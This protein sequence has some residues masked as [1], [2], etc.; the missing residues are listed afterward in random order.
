[1]VGQH[2]RKLDLFATIPWFMWYHINKLR[3]KELCLPI[4]K[5]FNITSNYLSEFQQRPQVSIAKTRQKEIKWK[6]LAKDEIKTSYDRAT[7]EDT[8]E[9]WI[10]VVVRLDSGEVLAAHY[11]K[12][13]L[14]SS[15]EVLEALIVRR[16]TQFVVEL[17]LHHLVF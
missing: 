5:I 7:F 11:E 15:V 12:I 14:P 13:P 17:G 4:E 16:A 6:P 3:L 10:V 8:G 1:M 2:T 9:A